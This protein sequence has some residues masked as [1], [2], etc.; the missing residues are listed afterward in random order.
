MYQQGPNGPD[1]RMQQLQQL[2]LR[3]VCLHQQ[4]AEAE[5]QQQQ[6][7]TWQLRATAASGKQQTN[8]AMSSAEADEN[9]EVVA[10]FNRLQEAYLTLNFLLWMLSPRPQPSAAAVSASGSRRHWS[11][12]MPD[13]NCNLKATGSQEVSDAVRCA[14]RTPQSTS[15]QSLVVKQPHQRC[16]CWHSKDNFSQ[17]SLMLQ[18]YLAEAEVHLRQ[19]L[20]VWREHEA[21]VMTLHQVVDR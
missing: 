9:P 21:L 18:E 19:L 2:G 20:L 13:S 1:I 8:D 4:E 12:W 7:P 15:G 16:L 3:L 10:Q 14:A 5:Q 6:P 11:R 17:A